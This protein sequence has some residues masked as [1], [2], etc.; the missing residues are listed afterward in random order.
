MAMWLA[1]GIRLLNL[2]RLRGKFVLISLFIFIPVLFANYLLVTQRVEEHADIAVELQGLAPLQ[3]VL[4]VLSR[5]QALHDF[6][7]AQ[8]NLRLSTEGQVSIEPLLQQAQS[9]LQDL[10]V[11]WPEPSSSVRF[12]QLRDE[13]GRG[14][15]GLAALPYS[16]RQSR[17]R[18]LLDRAPELLELAA[19]G[20]GLSQNRSALVRQS[21]TLLS[22]YSARIRELTGQARAVGAQALILGRLQGALSGQL[23]GTS[24]E[25]E[26]M[27]D[28]LNS[29]LVR[30][31]LPA[32]LAS[33][34]RDSAQGLRAIKQLIEER[35]LSADTLST[36]WQQYFDQVSTQL[37]LSLSFE[38][39]TLDG[40]RH[41]LETRQAQAQQ[42]T[43][44][45][46]LPMALTLFLIV[47]LYSAFYAAMRQALNGL[48]QALERLAAGDLRS[49][50]QGGYHVSGR[51]EFGGL[52]SVLSHSVRRIRELIAAGHTAVMQVEEQAAQVQAGASQSTE[53]M[54]AQRRMVEQIA[55]AMEQLGITAQNVAHGALST[56][57][58]AQHASAATSQGRGLVRAQAGGINQLA[59]GIKTA[60]QSI[61]RLAQ[62]SHSIG[63][64]LDVIKGIA[65]QTNLLALNAAIE[66]ARAG[67]H[68]RGFAVVADEVRGLARRT[69]LSTGEIEQMISQLQAGVAAAVQAMEASQEMASGS[70][71]Q[72]AH[73]QQDLE[74]ILSSIAA[75]AEQSQSI[76]TSA[77]EQMAVVA[78]IKRHVGDIGEAAANTLGSARQAQQASQGLSL[79]VGRLNGLIG[80][81]HL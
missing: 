33:S 4:T 3:G 74:R 17:I 8:K 61:Q 49:G 43:L 23:D 45:Q 34:V 22:R 76:S 35:L 72:S 65:E 54:A 39:A 29:V 62:S 73:V 63:Q 32:E 31:D 68:G 48:A 78:D 52:G 60:V 5:L 42:A 27:A 37:L 6:N 24:M 30:P 47:Y 69:Q 75:I 70:V 1:P 66:A 19:S 80:A 71:T 21:I 55:A 20:S 12:A 15:Q 28:E 38:Q 9:A 51:D 16:E 64:V 13:L 2:L 40:L 11:T 79:L 67:E 77:E 18:E 14:L 10:I 41:Q 36:P 44:L 59:S 7:L 50:S 58:S 53:A 25:L 56:A 26:G 81:F 46:V 57:D